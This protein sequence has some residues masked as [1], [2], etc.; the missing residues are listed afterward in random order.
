M[1][2]RKQ[3]KARRGLVLGCG[4]TLGAAWTV[5]TL[6]EVSH[7]LGWDP[8]EADVIV[9]TSAGSELAM[10]LGAGV[11]VQRILDAQLGKTESDPVLA[12]H[13]AHPPWR[14][15][16]SPLGMPASLS[17]VSSFLRGG[18]GGLAAL[19]GV[20]PE[21]RADASPIARLVDAYVPPGAWVPHAGTR[22]VVADVETGARAF[23]GAPSAP[24]ASMRDAV[25]ASLAMPGFFPAVDI[26]GRRYTDGG[27]AS[28]ASADLAVEEGIDELVVLAPMSSSEPGPRSGLGR[29][30]GLVRSAMRRILDREIDGA[31]ARGVRVLRLEP[32]AEDLAAMGPLLSDGR[33][34][35]GVLESS[36]RTARRTVRAALGRDGAFP[37]SSLREQGALEWQA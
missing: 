4:G 27:I 17:L 2:K 24:H 20:Y 21:G 18:G 11:S 14:F 6:A 36:L 22:I 26:A 13:F 7:R 34:R 37:V 23:L 9:G 8:R 35:L 12:Y 3:K 25:C 5:A 29:V 31:R 19:S 15:P 1:I 10:L 30:E 16:R 32:V 33:R 28:P